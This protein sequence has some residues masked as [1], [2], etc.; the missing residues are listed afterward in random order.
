MRS[1]QAPNLQANRSA[2]QAAAGKPNGPALEPRLQLAAP[3]DPKLSPYTG[4]TR[5]HWLEITERLLAGVLPYFDASSGLPKLPAPAGETAFNNGSAP[6]DVVPVEKQAFERIMMLGVIYSGATRRDTVPG[7]AGS[8][9]EPFRRGMMQVLDPRNPHYWGAPTKFEHAGSIFALGALLSPKY[10]WEAFTPAQRTLV[11]DY[12]GQLSTASS[13]DNNH[14]LFHLTPTPVLEANGRDGHRAHHTAMIERL[15]GMYRGDGWYLDGSNQSFDKYNAW[16]FHLYDQVIYRF[17]APWRR[18]FGAQIED[19]TRRFLSGYANL[20]GRDGGPI[21]WGRS[22][23]YRFAELAALGWASWNGMNPLPPGEARRIASGVL[24]YFWEHGAQDPDGLLQVGFRDTNAAVAEFYNGPGTSYWAAQGLIAL[25]IPATDP[26]WTAPEEPMPADTD[27]H[28]IVIAG[29]QL[30]ARTLPDG[31]ARLYPVGQPFSRAHDHWQRGVKYQQHAY[32]S[33]LGWCTLGE[34]TD[35]GAG[36]T[37]V[38]IDGQ[39]WQYRD[40]ARALALA[41]DHFASAWSF[42]LPLSYQPAADDRYDLVTHTLIGAA[43]ELHLF[44]HRSPQPLFLHLGG[45]GIGSPDTASIE[46]RQDATHLELRTPEYHSELRVCAAPEGS[47]SHDVLTPRPG[48]TH[49]HLFDR[50]GT[51]PI[52]RSLAAVP[53]NTPV[54]IYVDGGKANARQAP[55]IRLE[56]TPGKLTVH[57]DG[58]THVISVPW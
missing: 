12:L 53:A 3:L 52:W 17:D 32:S 13:Y 31:E 40:H 48:W 21:P 5:Q 6:K 27:A 42:D 29:A 10:F 28:T 33:A 22:L 51:F 35:L 14:Y 7:Y 58:K 24:R 50:V 9:T 11:L 4:Y 54:A 46:V 47:V 25:M 38:S 2:T 18:Q 15:L 55:D 39:T 34:G 26:F 49:A 20:V 56:H 37:G 57:F 45:Y 44:W 23:S 41:A 1:A 43:G 19:S 36:R 8:I 30:V 16:G